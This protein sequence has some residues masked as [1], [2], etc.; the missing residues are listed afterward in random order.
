MGHHLLHHG[1]ARQIAEIQ[2]HHYQVGALSCAQF[3]QGFSGSCGQADFL[4]AHA[5]HQRGGGRRA[6]TRMI[7]DYERIGHTISPM[8]RTCGEHRS[9]GHA[10]DVEGASDALRNFQTI[11]RTFRMLRT[12]FRRISP[13]PRDTRHRRSV[14]AEAPSADDN[15]EIFKNLTGIDLS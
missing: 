4:E 1:I 9:S 12:C 14:A 10:P 3:L 5:F 13:I 15:H 11:M 2:V 7:V 8:K 6:Y